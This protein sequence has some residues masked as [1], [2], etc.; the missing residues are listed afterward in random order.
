MRHAAWEYIRNRNFQVNGLAVPEDVNFIAFF[1]RDPSSQLLNSRF[2][3][4]E[5]NSILQ[6]GLD[7]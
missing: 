1:R 5:V 3:G 2:P 4:N 6:A 7:A